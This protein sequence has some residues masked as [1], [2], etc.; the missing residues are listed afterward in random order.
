MTE[1]INLP[2]KFNP[3]NWYSRV[4]QVR[5][6]AH[7]S[8]PL[9]SYIREYVHSHTHQCKEKNLTHDKFLKSISSF[10][11][12]HIACL[13]YH[14]VMEGPL[15][16]MSVVECP[17]LTP[18]NNPR[19]KHWV[20]ICGILRHARA[21]S[22]LELTILKKWSLAQYLVLLSKTFYLWLLQE[23]S[24]LRHS[25]LTTSKHSRIPAQ[26]WNQSFG[27]LVLFEVFKGHSSASEG[28]PH[29]WLWCILCQQCSSCQHN[30]THC[31]CADSQT[32][33][34]LWLLSWEELSS[35]MTSTS[36]LSPGVTTPLL[37]R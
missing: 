2:F 34:G 13:C 22:R 27:V 15:L 31:L 18:V 7:I 3:H 25:K 11:P 24:A 10:W 21:Q 4:S 1:Q 9:T 12:S 36:L 29:G 14:E 33:R 6:Q 23:A 8:S 5:E 26:M 17:Y 35:I 37:P 32:G 16:S 28:W 30:S 19:S 20:A